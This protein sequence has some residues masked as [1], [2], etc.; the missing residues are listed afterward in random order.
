MYPKMPVNKVRIIFA[1]SYAHLVDDGKGKNTVQEEQGMEYVYF[2]D[3]NVP[4]TTSA[5]CMKHGHYD[6]YISI[7]FT[8][9]IL[10]RK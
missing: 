10:S 3:A 6:K 1:Q 2:T 4:Y 7:Y 8:Q 9:S 5:V